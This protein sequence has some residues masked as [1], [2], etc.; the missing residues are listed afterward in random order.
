VKT[1]IAVTLLL[2]ST[3]AAQTQ[4]ADLAT[5]AATT[6][7]ADVWSPEAIAKDP[8]GYL[9]WIEVRTLNAHDTLKG[10]QVGIAQMLAALLKH[11]DGNI[12]RMAIGDNALVGLVATYNAAEAANTWPTKW[13]GR[14]MTRDSMQTQVVSLHRQMAVTKSLVKKVKAAT[15]HLQACQ[16]EIVK[17]EAEAMAVLAE[18]AASRE[19]LKV[20]E[21]N[22]PIRNKLAGL[23]PRVAA[24]AAT[25]TDAN[26]ITRDDLAEDPPPAKEPT[27]EQILN[28]YKE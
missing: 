6:K 13:Q 28:E 14:D 7:P 19:L 11:Q 15:Q 18:V 26:A 17:A 22:D 20:Q 1:F 12:Q 5:A 16:A 8:A 2:I 27:F 9:N 21:I 25:P 10:G 3:A 24:I 23:Q 4:P